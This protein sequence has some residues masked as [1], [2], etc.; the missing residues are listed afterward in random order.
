MNKKRNMH[1]VLSKKVFFILQFYVHMNRINI[2][3][4]FIFDGKIF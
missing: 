4:S 2:Q 3:A 1:D